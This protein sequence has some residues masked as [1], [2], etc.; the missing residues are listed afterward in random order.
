MAKSKYTTKKIGDKLYTFCEG[1]SRI[2]DCGLY[3]FINEE[4]QV[5]IPCIYE[6]ATLFHNG[7]SIV[8]KKGR[9]YNWIDRYGNILCNEWFSQA[10]FF[11]EGVAYA[12]KIGG[13]S[14][15]INAAGEEEIAFKYSGIG[16]FSNGV[17]VVCENEKWGYIDHDGKYIINPIYDFAETFKDG[18][19][20]VEI[21]DKNRKI[22][23]LGDYID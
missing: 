22:N 4:G 14:G 2:S 8:R 12:H 1:R 10:G 5:I 16:P 15:F 13:L 3:G 21:G 23:L 18:I 17:A 9:Y 19:A 6:R 7:F 20:K 11:M